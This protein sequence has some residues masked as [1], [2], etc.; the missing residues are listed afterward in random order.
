MCYNSRLINSPFVFSAARKNTL[1]IDSSTVDPSVS[2]TVA[3]HA[4]EYNLRFID[5]PVSGGM[6]HLLTL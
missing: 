4:R 5:S 1:L 2:Q 3:S 6:L